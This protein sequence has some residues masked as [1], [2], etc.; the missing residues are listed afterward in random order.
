[1]KLEVLHPLILIFIPLVV[2]YV[3]YMSKYIKTNKL[4]KKLIVVLRSIIL[5]LMILSLSGISMVWKA[6]NTT[7][8]FLADT[9]HSM[10]QNKDKVESFIKSAVSKKSANDLVGVVSFGEDAVVDSFVSPKNSFAKLEAQANGTYTN[11]ENALTTSLSLMGE[12]TKKRIVLV[13]DGEENEGKSEKLVPSLKEQGI[14]FKVYKIKKTL[15]EDVQ[16]EDISVP[17]T[18]RIGQKFNVGVN[19]KSNVN[20]SAKIV[21]FSDTQKKVEQKVQLN[22]GNNRFV[23]RDIAENGGFKTYKVIVDADKDSESKNNESSTFT[24]VKD[25]PR[26]L[27]ITD[28]QGEASEIVKMLKASNMDYDIVAAVGAPTTIKSLSK[29]KSI[30]M[31][32]VSAENLNDEF[33]NIL[34]SYVKDLGG[35]LIAVGGNNSYALGG[36]FKTPLEKVLPVYMDMRGKKEMPDMALNLVIDRS[37]S[38]DGAKIDLAKEAAARSL[39]ALREKDEIGVL[40]FDD[41]QYWVVERQK[42]ADKKKIRNDIGTIRSGGGTSILPAL[43]EAYQSIKQ[44]NAKIKHIIL[45]TDGQGE[46]NGFDELIDRMNKDNITVSTVS[47]GQDSDRLLLENIAKRAKGRFYYT[48]EGTNIPRIFAKEAFMASRTYLNNK[49]FTPIIQSSHTILQGAGENG[50]PSLLGY[51]GASPKNT[52]KVILKSDEEDPI[53][54]VWRYGLGKTVAWNSDMNGKWSANYIGWN[55][56]ITLWQNMI[57]WTIENYDDDNVMLEA[58][59]KDGKGEIHLTN[60]NSS[61]VLNTEAEIITPS[62]KKLKVNLNPSS[63]GEYSGEFNLKETGVYIIKAKQLKNGEMVSAAMT[64]ANLPYS[65]EYKMYNENNS[66]DLLLKESGGI[67]ISTPDEVFKGKIEDVLGKRYLTEILLII[68]LILFVLDIALRRLNLPFERIEEK[69]SKIKK[70][71]VK[72]KKKIVKS[73]DKKVKVHENND[74]NKHHTDESKVNKKVREKGKEQSQKEMLDTTALLKNKKK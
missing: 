30:I 51:I 61:E 19:I 72:D 6:Q 40:T 56:N 24:N 32:N 57:N 74:I 17:Q 41:S 10:N 71:H 9:S 33:L 43:E 73:D 34:E 14:D 66:L 58:S 52:A 25:K 60:K 62:M 8:I 31:C 2:I 64:G 36:Y 46:R 12:N 38:M 23:F 4:R 63:P 55:K 28:K 11:I 42:A 21:L 27:V 45:L 65:P 67:Y 70:Y 50:L 37:G 35:G 48:D 29:Y 68:A 18:L 53:L 3:V 5:T 13:S 20:T 1:M 54:T 15:G 7:T 39:D 16:V 49:E 22:K 26:I 59:I 69:L 47:V 44:S